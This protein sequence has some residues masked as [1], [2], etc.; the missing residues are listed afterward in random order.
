MS[1]LS[2]FLNPGKGYEKG[3]EQLDKYYNEAQGNLS[4]YNQ[5]GQNQYSNLNEMIQK[6]MNPGALEDEW[7]KNYKLSEN[8]KN[9]QGMAQQQGL[10]AASSMGLLG[11]SPALQAIQ[12]GTS[13]IGAADRQNYLNDLMEKYKTAAGLSQGIFGTG[14]NAAGAMSNNAM[15]MGQNSAQMAYNRENAGGNMFGGL[16]G[17]GGS[18]LGSAL[19]GPMGG[20][21]AKRWNLA[22]GA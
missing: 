16:L 14:A 22:G 20:A 2:S 17:L 12:A 4:P 15:N 11:S 9:M 7:I 13:Q 21:L 5:F 19:G 6:M 8:A 3:Q 10:D 1:W 18:I